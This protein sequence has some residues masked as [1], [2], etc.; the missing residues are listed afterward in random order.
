MKAPPSICT[1]TDY[2]QTNAATYLG[3]YG[4]PS[5]AASVTARQNFISGILNNDYDTEYVAQTI[6]NVGFRYLP[7]NAK[8]DVFRYSDIQHAYLTMYEGSN[9]NSSN[10]AGQK[11][12]LF[13]FMVYDSGTNGAHDYHIVCSEGYGEVDRYINHTAS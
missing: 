11:L 5:E 10:Y 9:V 4:T 6:N 2:R 12:R 3:N 8:D 7:F 13:S 1:G